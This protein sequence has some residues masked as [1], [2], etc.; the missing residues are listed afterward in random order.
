M[1]YASSLN[2]L[3][4]KKGVKQVEMVIALTICQCLALIALTGLL[5]LLLIELFKIQCQG[6][7]PLAM[8]IS[9]FYGVCGIFEGTVNREK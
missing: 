4:Y 7:L 3:L 8:I 6:S 2:I 5:Y 1:A 9:I